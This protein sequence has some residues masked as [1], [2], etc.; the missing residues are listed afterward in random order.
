[1]IHQ[2]DRTLKDEW[3]K[4][5]RELPVEARQALKAALLSLRMDALQRAQ[6]QWERHKGPMAL[7]WKCVGVYAGHLARSIN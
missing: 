3:G 2:A 6:I 4:I 5:F 7:Y 1:M